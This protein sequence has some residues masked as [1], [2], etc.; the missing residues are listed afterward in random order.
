MPKNPGS[1][2]ASTHTA[3]RLTPGRDGVEH[4]VERRAQDHPL[5]VVRGSG[6]ADEVELARRADDHLGAVD[7]GACGRPEALA[8][9][10]A[11]DGDGLRHR[12]PRRS[13]AVASARNECA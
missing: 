4:V 10:Q 6:R 13:S 2:D 3:A 12:R 9:D 8:A 1:P 11:D 5:G 7:R